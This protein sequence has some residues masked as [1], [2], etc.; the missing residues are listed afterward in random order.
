M[1]S[2]SVQTQDGQRLDSRAFT[3]HALDFPCLVY[4]WC[5]DACSYEHIEMRLGPGLQTSRPHSTLMYARNAR[6][7]R[8]WQYEHSN[9][10]S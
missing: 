1:T 6:D 3:Y 7:L 2:Y 8:R 4:R 5:N 9:D 10:E